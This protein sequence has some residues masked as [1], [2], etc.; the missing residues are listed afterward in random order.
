MTLKR[1]NRS[2]RSND[3][4]ADKSIVSRRSLKAREDCRDYVFTTPT[5]LSIPPSEGNEIRCQL[6]RHRFHFNCHFLLLSYLN[7]NPE[8]LEYGKKKKKKKRNSFSFSRRLWIFTVVDRKLS[9]FNLLEIT[10]NCQRGWTILQAQH[11]YAKVSILFLFFSPYYS[12]TGDA[13][14]YE[15]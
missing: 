2:Q 4:T 12:P 7:G 13:N 8:C 9:V 5:S 6:S 3:C 11:Y 14:E 10:I 1:E 15:R